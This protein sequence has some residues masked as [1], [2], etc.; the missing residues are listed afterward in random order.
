[1]SEV[2]SALFIIPLWSIDSKIYV[3]VHKDLGTVDRAK[4]EVL[5]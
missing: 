2:H 5:V 1:M 4:L 3:Q